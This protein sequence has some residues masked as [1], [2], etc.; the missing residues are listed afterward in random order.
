MFSQIK[1][2]IKNEILE[3]IGRLLYVVIFGSKQIKPVYSSNGLLKEMQF[4]VVVIVLSGIY[5]VF[6]CFDNLL[7]SYIGLLF[8]FYAY[9]MTIQKRCRDFGSGGTFWILL[10]SGAFIISMS[11]HFINITTAD[12]WVKDISLLALLVQ[13]A[14]FLTLAIIPSKENADLSLK[15][16]LLQYPFLYVAICWGLAVAATI[17]VNCFLAM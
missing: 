1:D 5:S 10:S 4:L 2:I 17:S 11:F 6:N 7:L 9:L 15:S 3:P 13:L 12:F 8:L 14:V 16:P